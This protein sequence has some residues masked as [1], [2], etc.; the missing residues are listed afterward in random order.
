MY[1]AYA[2]RYDNKS[3]EALIVGAF[4]EA[5]RASLIVARNFKL[6]TGNIHA[7]DGI[8]LLL[9]HIFHV[10]VLDRWSWLLRTTSHEH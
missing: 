6:M 7:V 5:K 9:L 8:I 2:A 4:C 10:L 1:D 3:L